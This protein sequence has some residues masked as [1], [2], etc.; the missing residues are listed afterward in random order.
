MKD[1]KVKGDDSSSIT[2]SPTR[3]LIKPNPGDFIK[4]NLFQKPFEKLSDILK[5]ASPDSESE[6]DQQPPINKYIIIKNYGFIKLDFL[7]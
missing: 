4:P 6:S 2:N 1:M 3:K 5:T 7:Y